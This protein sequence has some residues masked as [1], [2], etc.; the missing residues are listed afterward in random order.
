MAQ[1]LIINQ[2]NKPMDYTNARKE[3]E[4]AG[5]DVAFYHFQLHHIQ[6]DA[7]TMAD[8]K[9]VKNWDLIN[10]IN[11]TKRKLKQA[12]ERLALAKTNERI[13][14]KAYQK[15]INSCNSKHLLA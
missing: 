6:D 1:K 14:W 2:P 13:A 8:L 12:E 9:R 7:P 4:D 10:Q 3:V 11:E 5:S 15:E